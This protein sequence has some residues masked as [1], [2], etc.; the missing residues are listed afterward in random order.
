MGKISEIPIFPIFLTVF[1]AKVI[2]FS[3]T[4]QQ[5]KQTT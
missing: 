2:N 5:I 1:L 4:L 3:I